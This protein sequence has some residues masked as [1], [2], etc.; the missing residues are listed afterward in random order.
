MIK[1]NLYILSIVVF[2]SLTGL[3]CFAKEDPSK[4]LPKTKDTA[5]DADDKSDLTAIN[6]EEEVSN[7]ED[8]FKLIAI[9]LVGNR[10][11]ALIKDLEKPEDPAKEFQVGDYVDELQTFL[12]SK[13]LL[14]PTTRIELIDLNGLSYILKEK[15][16]DSSNNS[17]SSKSSPSYSSNSNKI[18]IKRATTTSVKTPIEGASAT[19]TKPTEKKEESTS[20]ESAVKNDAASTT[21]TSPPPAQPAPGPAQN[22]APAQQDTSSIQAQSTLGGTPQAQS[23]TTATPPAGNTDLMSTSG[24]AGADPTRP[25]NPFGE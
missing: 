3:V 4:I 15:N 5:K 14:N 21:T 19:V 2:F 17:T 23:N 25:S 20:L 18:K 11:R 7:P 10:P 13:I 9:Y 8:N 6:D 22:T 16:T 24:G 12:I 1:S